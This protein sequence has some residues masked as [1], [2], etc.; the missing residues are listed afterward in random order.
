MMVDMVCCKAN[1]SVVTQRSYS[2]VSCK[3][4][5]EVHIWWFY[6]CSSLVPL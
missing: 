3:T 1:E 4:P 5:Q 2:A 6:L